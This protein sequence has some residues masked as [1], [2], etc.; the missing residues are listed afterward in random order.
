MNI[1]RAKQEIIHTVKAYTARTPNGR[2]KI[3]VPRQRPILMIGPPGIGK[4]EIVRQAADFC[5]V[6]F[7]AYTITHHTRQSAVGLPV[8]TT[9]S[10]AGTEYEVTHYTMS[11]I[12]GALYRCMEETGKKEG[13][14]FIDEINCVSETLMPAMLQLLQ[15]KTFGEY[16][17]PEG[18]VIVTA[19]N[20]YVYN[21]SVREFDMV[22]LDRVKRLD[23][24]PDYPVWRRYAISRQMHGA[25]L[26]F[27]ESRKDR[28]YYAKREGKKLQ[29]VTARGWE[30]LSDIL[31][32]YECLKIDVDEELIFQ[33]LQCETIAGEFYS[34]YRLYTRYCA[35]FDL[36]MKGP[37]KDKNCF[38]QRAVAAD[39]EEKCGMTQYA[40]SRIAEATQAWY[41]TDREIKD[42]QK[43]GQLF[44]DSLT[45]GEKISK[46]ISPGE[47]VE[48]QKKAL[49]IKQ[50]AGILSGELL[51]K[52]EDAIRCLEKLYTLGKSQSAG[53]IPAW[54][55]AVDA[56]IQEQKKEQESQKAYTSQTVHE[57]LQIFADAWKES[58]EAQYLRLI[59]NLTQHEASVMF[60]KETKEPLY[61]NALP[62]LIL[63]DER[64]ALLKEA[65]KLQNTQEKTV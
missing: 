17:V 3:P 34:W 52:E 63:E 23:V 48:K 43:T 25:V 11:E 31:K 55:R 22:T 16:A 36:L 57:L 58:D 33:Y 45:R 56:C 50:Q 62:R 47:F 18:W 5:D 2:F 59:E 20:P 46:K 40:F 61:E 13:I 27:L 32:E 49:Q 35:D 65:R 4:T 51:E 39:W 10:F 12:I 41:D 60:L 7:V 54:K 6:G 1:E 15:G 9:E 53:D 29:F 8:I 24:E 19:G 26:F 64:Q 37:Q 44:I 14:L 28:F 42:T 30:D 38:L 21:T